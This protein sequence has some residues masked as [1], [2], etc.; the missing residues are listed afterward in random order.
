MPEM[1]PIPPCPGEWLIYCYHP[2][3]KLRWGDN[4][5]P[6]QRFLIESGRWYCCELM[7]KAN[8]VGKRDGRTAF[9]VDGKLIGDFPNLHFRDVGTLKINSLTLTLYIANNRIRENRMWYDDV[10]VATSYIGPIAG[11][12]PR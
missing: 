4:F 5:E 8:T 12:A 9:W 10:V 7:L 1:D 11:D 3:Q 2:E 6:K